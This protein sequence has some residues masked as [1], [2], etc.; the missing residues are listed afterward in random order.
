MDSLLETIDDY[1]FDAE[2]YFFGISKKNRR[3][4]KEQERLKAKI[5]VEDFIQKA[6]DYIFG[7]SEEEQARRRRQELF[8]SM[9]EETI[10]RTLYRH[11]RSLMRQAQEQRRR[12]EKVNPDY[13]LARQEDMIESTERLSKE[14]PFPDSVLIRRR[15]GTKSSRLEY[16]IKRRQREES[17]LD[18]LL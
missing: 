18:D 10:D 11:S 4:R 17:I 2:D 7:V 5:A 8:C 14:M 16:R 15:V 1:L 12:G 3:L 9:F 13:E 6:K